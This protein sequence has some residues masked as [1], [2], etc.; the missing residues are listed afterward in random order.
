MPGTIDAANN[1]PTE[2]DNKSPM[3]TS[4]MEG[5]IKMPSVPAEA[6]VPVASSLAYPRSIIDGSA[7]IVSMT[8]EAPTIPVV[9]AMIVPIKVTDMARPPGIRLVTI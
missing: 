9:A 3:I 1:A 8:T 2:T 6:I 5:G 4:I 7:I